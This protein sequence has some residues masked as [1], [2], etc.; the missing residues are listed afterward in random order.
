MKKY[1]VAAS[2]VG[3][4]LLAPATYAMEQKMDD[5][6]MMMEQTSMPSTTM[7]KDDSKMMMDDM[8]QDHNMMMNKMMMGS[9]MKGDMMMYRGAGSYALHKTLMVIYG[10]LTLLIL[11]LGNIALFKHVSKKK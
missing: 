11:V 7:M 10:L 8:M 6:S 5:S 4:V 9:N 2:L 3:A 1:V